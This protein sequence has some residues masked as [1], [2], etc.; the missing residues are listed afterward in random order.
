MFVL[1]LQQENMIKIC[2]KKRKK[3]LKPT[4][5]CFLALFSLKMHKVAPTEGTGAV[6]ELDWWE[7][8]GHHVSH[9]LLL[10]MLWSPNMGLGSQMFQET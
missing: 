8:G 10:L 9:E 1:L 4:H 5:I 3:R 2:K 7:R 6:T